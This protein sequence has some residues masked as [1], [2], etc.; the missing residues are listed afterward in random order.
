MQIAWGLYDQ[1]HQA[2]T[3]ETHIVYPEGFTIPSAAQ[4][5]HGISTERA[6]SEGRPATDVLS[7]LSD[8]AKQASVIAAHN[9]S[10]D[11]S[12]LAVEYIRLG[13]PPP[14]EP[15]EM[16]C[17]MRQTADYCCIPGPYGNKWPTLEELYGFL[18]NET[19][20]GTHDAGVDVAAS[21]CCFFEL[22]NRGVIQIT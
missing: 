7:R 9:A 8:A 1:Q 3:A 2:M 15:Q 4:R 20:S 11:G 12:V 18:F 22:K 16:I 5:I 13:L 14:F 10:F 17:T 19:L 6:R 21:A